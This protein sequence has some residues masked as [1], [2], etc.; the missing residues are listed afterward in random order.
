M[1]ERAATSVCMKYRL[2]F[3]VN[4][5]GILL[6]LLLLFAYGISIKLKDSHYI[7]YWR[8]K[9]SLIFFSKSVVSLYFQKK[10]VVIYNGGG[11]KAP[12]Y[13]L[14]FLRK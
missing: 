6:L 13:G 5:A 11:H 8:I 4:S 10:K 2:L 14:N 12:S 1:Y 7:W 9:I 3:S